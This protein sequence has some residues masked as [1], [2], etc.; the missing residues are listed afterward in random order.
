[1]ESSATLFNGFHLLCLFHSDSSVEEDPVNCVG[2][3]LYV[4]DTVWEGIEK[5]HVNELPYDINGTK[6]YVL[7]YDSLNTMKVTATDGRNWQRYRMSNKTIVTDMRSMTNWEGMWICQNKS[8]EF[9][10]E[11]QQGDILRTK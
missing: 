1:M 9:F 8:W 4:L 7:P 11:H 10:Q 6:M 5:Q 3:R 2:N